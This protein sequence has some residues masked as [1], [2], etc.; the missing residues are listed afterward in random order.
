MG[1]KSVVLQRRVQGRPVTEATASRSGLNV[2]PLTLASSCDHSLRPDGRPRALHRGGHRLAAPSGRRRAADRRPR[3]RRHRAVGADQ[4]RQLHR[5]RPLT[6]VECRDPVLPRLRRAADQTRVEGP[7]HRS[8][9]DRADRRHRR[10][11]LVRRDPHARARRTGAASACGKR[12]RGHQHPHRRAH[13]AQQ[14]QRSAHTEPPRAHLQPVR[15]RPVRHDRVRRLPRPRRTERPTARRATSIRRPDPAG[16]RRHRHLRQPERAEAFNR[17]GFDG[18][19]EGESLAEVTTD[20]LRGKI[21]IDESCRSSS[22]GA[23]RGAP[24][25][26]RAASPSR[27][28]PSRSATTASGSARSSSSAT[29]PRCGTKSKSSSPKM[30]RSARSTTA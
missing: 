6:P 13:P 30:R 25:S 17:M 2:A 12:C 7:G 29:S 21:V 9:R 22:P 28:A 3:V 8:L 14:P 23:H 1:R 27:C 5:R 16:Y 11:R 20:L 15:Q 26:K 10:T 4:R 19:L 18:E 24:T